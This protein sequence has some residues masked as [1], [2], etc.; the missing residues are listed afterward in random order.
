MD[1]PAGA[2]EH[3]GGSRIMC[4]HE[5]LK[6]KGDGQGIEVSKPG[7]PQDF[8][9]QKAQTNCAMTSKTSQGGFYA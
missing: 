5:L 6:W 4:A 7:S 1:T 9:K 3:K 2:G 8:Q